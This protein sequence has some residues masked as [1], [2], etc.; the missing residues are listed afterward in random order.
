MMC[1]CDSVSTLKSNEATLFKR[2]YLEAVKVDSV[3]WTALYR[4]KECQVF[5][6][7]TFEDGR[8]GG[9]EILNKVDEE[10]VKKNWKL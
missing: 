7:E 4:C 10:Y 1:E 9:T 3:N 5:W 2:K 8:W 6:E